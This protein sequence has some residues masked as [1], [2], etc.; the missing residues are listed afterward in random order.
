MLNTQHLEETIIAIHNQAHRSC[1]SYREE[2][3]AER[4]DQ[5][6]VKLPHDERD[7]FMRLALM[8]GYK[9]PAERSQSYRP[10]ED[11]F[12]DDFYDDM[13]PLEDDD[14]LH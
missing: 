6:L 3:F 4:I 1:E 14:W 7:E 5:E 12:S 10:E 9:T 13:F 11:G 2:Y 8:H